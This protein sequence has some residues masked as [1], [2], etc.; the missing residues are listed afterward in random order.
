MTAPLAETGA[1]EN[2]KA[3]P[4]DRLTFVAFVPA[5]AVSHARAWWLKL[6]APSARHCLVV[7]AYGPGVTGVMN[8]AGTALQMMMLEEPPEQVLRRLLAAGG[9]ILVMQRPTAAPKPA[10]RPIMSCVEVC[11]AMLQITAWWV[12]TPA[13]LERHLRK[14][15]ANQLIVAPEA[16]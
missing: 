1:P 5:S 13:Q 6:L 2:G 16:A 11:K 12:L 8:H 3:Y 9:R 15:G 14:L 10:L 4:M 7:Q